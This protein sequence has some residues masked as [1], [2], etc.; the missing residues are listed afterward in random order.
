[1]R[2][3]TR[4]SLPVLLGTLLSFSCQR[5]QDSKRPPPATRPATAPMTLAASFARIEA[6][7]RPY[8]SADD[9]H[10]WAMKVRALSADRFGFWRGAKDLFFEWC[11]KSAA[12]WMADRESYVT[13]Q[14]DPHFGNI[15]TYLADGME[16]GPLAFGMVDFDDSHRGPFQTELL[17]GLITFRLAARQGKVPLPEHRVDQLLELVRENYLAAARSSEPAAKLL[18]GEP[19]IVKLMVPKRKRQYASELARYTNGGRFLPVVFSGK[20]RVK[21]LLRPGMDKADDVAAAVAQAIARSPHLQARFRYHD[22]QALRLRIRDLARRTRPG[23]SGSQGLEKLFVLMDRPLNGVEHD[24]ILYIKQQVPTAA[25][26]VGLIERDPRPPG[27]RCAQDIAQLSDPNL[28]LSGWC[29]MGEHTYWLTV[30][31]PWTEELDEE[32]IQ[33]WDNLKEFARIWAVSAGATHRQ[34]GE[35]QRIAAR[36]TP[37]LT[38]QLKTR[39]AEYLLQLERDY[40]SFI[41]DPNVPP[42]VEAAEAL[43]GGLAPERQAE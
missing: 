9:P 42:L 4:W 32:D 37:A 19:A 11:K 35:A 3:R 22:A 40:A 25:E 28:Y 16:L 12:D 5:E 15:G 36:L 6:T 14:G 2:S 38:A 41:A 17:Q 18:G 10:E 13:Q 39:S 21:D 24:V 26:R 27:Q 33:S 30:R 34:P 20:Q 7:Y 1:M 23:S 43:L 31:E 29:T 8:L